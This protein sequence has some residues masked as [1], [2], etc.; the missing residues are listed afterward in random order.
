MRCGEIKSLSW[1][2]VSDNTIRL[3]GI[4][5]KTRKPRT[6]VCSGELVDVRERRRQA[7]AVKNPA[8][9]TMAGNTFHREGSPVGEF[10][11]S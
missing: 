3:R 4:D 5:A 10:R 7:R 6:I 2:S 8:G 11:K 9:V 1:S